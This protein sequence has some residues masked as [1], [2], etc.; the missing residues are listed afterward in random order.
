[1]KNKKALILFLIGV[2][3]LPSFIYCAFL[4]LKEK[5]SKELTEFQNFEED[6]TETEKDSCE[7]HFFTIHYLTLSIT[8]YVLKAKYEYAGYKNLQLYFIFIVVPP[9][10]NS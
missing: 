10:E 3:I 2:I 1:M 4:I 8:Q 5:T 7:K 9:P 6:E